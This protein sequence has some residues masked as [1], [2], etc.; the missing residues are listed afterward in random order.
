M[1]DS[2]EITVARRVLQLDPDRIRPMIFTFEAYALSNI[3]NVTGF[4][5]EIKVADRSRQP[6]LRRLLRALPTE[7]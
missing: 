6:D 4:H 1:I 3:T 7:A 5:P 2:F